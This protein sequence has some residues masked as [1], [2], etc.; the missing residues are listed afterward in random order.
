MLQ[1]L[2]GRA[3]LEGVLRAFLAHML[4]NWVVLLDEFINRHEAAADSQDE[5]IIL[6]LHDDLICEV[7]VATLGLSHEQTFD[8]LL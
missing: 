8:T 2:G 1:K 3:A 4:R 5:V 7:A 6:H